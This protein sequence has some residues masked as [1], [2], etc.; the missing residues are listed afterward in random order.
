MSHFQDVPLGQHI[1]LVAQNSNHAKSFLKLAF[2][3]LELLCENTTSAV[4]VAWVFYNL[5]YT[6][7]KFR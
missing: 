3:S 4:I 6:A 2:L 1:F 5:D 7:C